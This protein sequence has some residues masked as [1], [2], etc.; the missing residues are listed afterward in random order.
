MP[1]FTMKIYMKDA[2]TKPCLYTE[3]VPLSLKAR[4]K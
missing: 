3:N 1:H 2:R 4:T